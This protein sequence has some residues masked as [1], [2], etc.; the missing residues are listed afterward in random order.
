MTTPGHRF[1][2]FTANRRMVAASVSVGKEANT[3]HGLT[4][5]DVTGP[6]RLIREHK[7]RAGE[8]L[9][10]TAYVVACLARTLA[11]QPELNCFRRGRRLVILDDITINTLVER[12]VAGE[13][14]PEPH[15]VHA[16]QNKTFRQIHDEIRA[17]QR[18]HDDV[19]A[20]GS[21]I[22]WLLRV[23]PAFLA[24][25]IVRGATRNIA[26]ARRYGVVG[27]TAIGMFGEGASWAIPLTSATI[28]V[29]VGSIVRRPVLVD[30]AL[31]EREH[32]CLTLSFNH[33]IV[34]G[35]PAARFI[36]RLGEVLAGGEALRNAATA[37]TRG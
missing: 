32:L 20:R 26:M 12:D 1:V 37:A 15:P 16:A 3:I 31:E 22:G 14:V 9:S 36:K 8:T 11:E 27:V 30:G 10:L 5:V 21:G 29:T 18:Q 4:E 7:Q 34:D 19:L 35:A 25:A 23:M 17:A 13:K 6:R 2:P 28:T 24:R 33:D